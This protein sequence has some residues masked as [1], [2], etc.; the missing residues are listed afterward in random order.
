M[1]SNTQ[2]RYVFAVGFS[3]TKQFEVQKLTRGQEVWLT[4]SDN[5]TPLFILRRI[6]TKLAENSD[7]FIKM[8]VDIDAN[9][10]KFTQKQKINQKTK[11]SGDSGVT[12]AD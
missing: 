7:N 6:C 3:V 2:S 12:M 9:P 1:R 11:T 8:V 5:Q 4:G 10:R